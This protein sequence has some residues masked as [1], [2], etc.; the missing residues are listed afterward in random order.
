MQVPPWACIGSSKRQGDKGE[1]AL[2]LGANP[3][4]APRQVVTGVG[5][6]LEP[7]AEDRLP[8]LTLLLTTLW[9]WVGLW[10]QLSSTKWEWLEDH[11]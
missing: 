7:V 2:L 4:E 11:Y 9:T 3:P 6:R 10:V 1:A 5:P 8:G